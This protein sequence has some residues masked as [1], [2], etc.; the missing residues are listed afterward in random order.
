MSVRSFVC[1]L[2]RMRVRV[3]N[4]GETTERGETS[5]PI[6]AKTRKEKTNPGDE[7]RRRLG[8]CC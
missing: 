3:N 8:S 6:G 1:S 7:S 2:D 4:E 5:E